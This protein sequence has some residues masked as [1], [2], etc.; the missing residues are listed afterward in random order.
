MLV[1]YYDEDKVE[2]YELSRDPGEA[3][4]VAAQEPARVAKMRTDLAA[5]RKDVNA[6]SNKP[7]SEFDAAKFRDLY[8]D[9]DASRFDPLHAN[10]AEWEKMWQWRKE[11]NAVVPKAKP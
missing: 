10:L 8:I 6:Q 1:E 3:R 7:N 5:W 11:M 9:V 4:D 2:L